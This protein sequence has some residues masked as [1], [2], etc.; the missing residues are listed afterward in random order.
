MKLVFSLFLLGV[1]GAASAGVGIAAR[2]GG[3]GRKDVSLRH[4]HYDTSYDLSA[5]RREPVR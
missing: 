3:I 1:L 2:N 5:R 4:I